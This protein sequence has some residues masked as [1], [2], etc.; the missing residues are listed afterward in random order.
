VSKQQ[1][2]IKRAKK[3]INRT[4]LGLCIEIG[5]KVPS[6]GV[7]D[8]RE[9]WEKAERH[10]GRELWDY[11]VIYMG[12]WLL[13]EVLQKLEAEEDVDFIKDY[14]GTIGDLYLSPRKMLLVERVRLLRILRLKQSKTR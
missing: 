14:N 10:R 2:W 1:L 3:Y 7:V 12:L 9:I 11:E 5:I 13:G 4:F 6:N 8:F